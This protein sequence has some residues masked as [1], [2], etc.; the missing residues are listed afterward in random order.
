MANILV[1][2]DEAKMTYL[3]E[4]ALVEAGFTVTAVNSP[5]EAISLIE[6]H[7]YDIIITDLSMPGITGMEIIEKARHKGD[8][9]VIVMTA[10]GT[11]ASAVEAMKKG[12]ADY[13]VK[14][15]PMDE[16]V[17]LC[18]R[19]SHNQKIRGL[20]NLLA[21]DLKSM[22]YDRFIGQSEAARQMLEMIS[23]VAAS[24]ATVLL[25]GK[26]GTGKEL[27][28]H[29]VHENSPRRDKPFIAVNCAALTETLLESELFGHERGAF[30]GADKRKLGRFEL[31][32]GGTIFLDEIG[33]TSPSLQAKLLRILEERQFV[34]VGGVDN[35]EVDVRVIAATNR[36][37]KE[38]IAAGIFRE[39]LYF[40]L[41]VFPIRIP[42][43]TERRE[44]I[45]PLA[46]YFLKQ[47]K[48]AHP[49]LSGEVVSS[50]QSYD[51]PGNIRELKNIMERAM[52][53]A[54]GERI[55]LEH[56]GIEDETETAPLETA[57]FKTGG[58]LEAGE[59]EMILEALRKSGGNKTE[60]AR[61]LKITRR[62]LYSRMKYHD[63]K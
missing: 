44:D 49:D 58:G 40:R 19:L 4:G 6:R 50:L 34:R 31:A 39:D 38:D 61:I 8:A 37:L 53:L 15:F 1:I 20:S 29:L 13:I 11:V 59:R 21:G 55:D 27:A 33:E 41:N 14:P 48:Y 63:I 5:V 2:D 9:D 47:K 52:I 22:S 46:E 62:R 17:L 28:A 32:D 30:T 12:A 36:K 24:D 25:T 51:W 18:R 56:I 57:G 45:P 23:K 10:Y 43:L 35:V 54:A 7:S 60:A 3:V 26:S 16:L 42:S